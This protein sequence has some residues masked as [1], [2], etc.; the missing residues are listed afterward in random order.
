[1]NTGESTFFFLLPRFSPDLS[2][3]GQ[4]RYT[5]DR[6][7]IYFLFLEV[8]ADRCTRILDIRRVTVKK[9]A[10][11]KHVRGLHVLMLIPQQLLKWT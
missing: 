9:K 5:T 8:T 3:H 10:P 4:F 11:W 7:G 1:M 2:L 6:Q